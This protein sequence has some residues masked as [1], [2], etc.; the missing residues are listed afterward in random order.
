MVSFSEKESNIGI[1]G[2]LVAVAAL[3]VSTACQRMGRYRSPRTIY[4]VDY[5]YLAEDQTKL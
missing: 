4:S 2:W 1:F 3:K 5:Q